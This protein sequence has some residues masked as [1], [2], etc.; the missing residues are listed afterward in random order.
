MCNDTSN[1]EKDLFELVSNMNIGDIFSEGLLKL[2]MKDILEGGYI[3][4]NYEGVI[5]SFDSNLLSL[6][7]GDKLLCIDPCIMS[8]GQDSLTVGGT[9]TVTSL[10]VMFDSIVFGVIDDEQS[11]HGFKLCD[12]Y[13]FFEIK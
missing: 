13:E 8:D 12:L 1:A 6:Q 10:D 3:K 4:T 2:P 11:P 7:S 9:Y 5:E